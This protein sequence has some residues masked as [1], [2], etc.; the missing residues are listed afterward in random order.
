M[1]VTYEMLDVTGLWDYEDVA[2]PIPPKP[3]E[4]K[5]AQFIR[6]DHVS[7]PCATNLVRSFVRISCTLPLKLDGFPKV[8]KVCLRP[9][10]LD[11]LLLTLPRLGLASWSMRTKVW[12]WYQGLLYRTICAT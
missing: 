9:I 2:D 7:H 11:V 5:K 8:R 3:L 1:E 4:P 10:S 6:L 12:C